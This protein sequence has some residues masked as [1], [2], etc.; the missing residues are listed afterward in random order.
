MPV[1]KSN[2]GYQYGKTGKT[3][4]GPDAKR[5]AILQGYAI[6]KSQESRGE[7]PDYKPV[8]KRIH[9]ATRGREIVAHLRQWGFLSKKL[10]EI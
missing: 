7:T 9:K 4:Y 3:Y 5:K 10:R 8:M 1:H 2:G 6:E